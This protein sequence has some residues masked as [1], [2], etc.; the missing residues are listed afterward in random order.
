MFYLTTVI[1]KYIASGHTVFF[2]D[3]FNTD[4]DVTF[5]DVI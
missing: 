3:H 4:D 2:S 5:T 1:N